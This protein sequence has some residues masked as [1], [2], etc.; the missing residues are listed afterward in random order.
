LLGCVTG[1][2]NSTAF[3]GFVQTSGNTGIDFG[4][5]DG[6]NYR[7]TMTTSGQLSFRY[8]V[9]GQTY[10]SNP[11]VAVFNL[12]ADTTQ[13]LGYASTSTSYTGTATVTLPNPGPGEQSV[14]TSTFNFTSSTM[15]AA[16][17]TDMQLNSG[18][19]AGSTQLNFRSN[20]LNVSATLDGSFNYAP[21]SSGTLNVPAS[22][23][24]AQAGNSDPAFVYVNGSLGVDPTDPAPEPA[25]FV[26]MGGAL[27]VGL[28]V[29]RRF[30]R[31]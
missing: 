25:S 26:L 29:Y 14:Y 27:L 11:E 1:F 9:D 28:A 21:L 24:V 16:F 31:T 20:A 23:L 12:V 22:S 6:G 18:D 13:P 8:V 5:I 3:N 10:D 17:F 30:V 4:T 15:P 7:V 2:A 19:P